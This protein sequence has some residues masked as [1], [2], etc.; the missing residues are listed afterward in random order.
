MRY[1]AVVLLL[2][3]LPSVAFSKG[4]FATNKPPGVPVNTAVPTITGT[5]QVGQT[6]TEHHG[7][8]TNGP[9]GYT[10]LWNGAGSPLNM[11]TYV[12]VT[13]DIGNTLTV[14]ETASNI[15]GS[16]TGATSVATGT[17]IAASS[18]GLQLA[19]TLQIGSIPPVN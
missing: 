14:T 12:P 19:L 7:S 5:A 15:R 3:L 18:S 13:G 8:W 2:F 10:Y 11:Q 17:V 16:S 6:L 9:T 1:V 4:F